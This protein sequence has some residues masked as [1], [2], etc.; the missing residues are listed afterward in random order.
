VIKAQ[1]GNLMAIK[2]VTAPIGIEKITGV[3]YANLS[4]PPP[5]PPPS[6]D[7]IKIKPIDS[8]NP[9]MILLDGAIIDKTKMDAINPDDMESM[10]VLKDK[11]S[12]T[13]LYGEKAKNGVIMITTKI[14][15]SAS[16]DS[17]SSKVY[18]VVEEMPEF[19]GGLDALRDFCVKNMK[20]P[21]AA[22]KMN[23]Q[24]TVIVNF[25]VNSRGKVEGAKIV[26][27]VH[28]SIDAEAIRIVGLLS[29]KSDWKPGKQ[30]G[31]AVDVSY[32]FPIEFML[33]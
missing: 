9:P 3:G 33:Q 12:T 32:T 28:P 1:S 20:Y 21:T 4:G 18:N 16:N 23:A 7:G 19:P 29:S 10:Y 26:R 6:A 22:I 8:Q 15:P 24:G 13:D 30:H 11:A 14:K 17:K 31:I 5:P 25:V 27:G 2:M